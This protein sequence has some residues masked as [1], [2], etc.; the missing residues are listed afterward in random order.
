MASLAYEEDWKEH[1]VNKGVPDQGSAHRVAVAGDHIEDSGR[2]A[3]LSNQLCQPQCC[4]HRLLC[5][6]HTTM[7]LNKHC[8]APFVQH[9]WSQQAKDEC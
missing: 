1:L 7:S 5:W 2:E 6:L 4:Q 3:G 9:Y 8:Q